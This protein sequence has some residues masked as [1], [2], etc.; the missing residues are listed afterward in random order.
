MVKHTILKRIY[1]SGP[2]PSGSGNPGEEKVKRLF[3]PEGME[4]TTETNR[5]DS[6]YKLIATVAAGTELA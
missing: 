3:Q 4:D 6:Q 1:L 5:T 2:P